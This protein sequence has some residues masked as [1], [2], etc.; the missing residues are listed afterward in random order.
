MKDIYKFL[1]TSESYSLLKYEQ[2]IRIFNK[3][4]TFHWRDV[5]QVDLFYVDR[6]KD[7]N[8]G[9]KYILTAI[10]VF[11]RFGFCEPIKDK[12]GPTV[13]NKLKTIFN[14]LG[15]LPKTIC[16]DQGS[17]FKNCHIVNYLKGH[18]IKSVYAQADPKAACVE[19][20]QKHSRF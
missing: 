10:D 9:V 16:S 19:R 11:T 7:E 15:V 8:D 18:K 14:R 4:I 20:L 5:I 13:T 17:E 1:E 6:L 3:T 12:S 2:P